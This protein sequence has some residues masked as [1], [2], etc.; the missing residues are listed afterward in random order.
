M[1][2]SEQL[3]I[4]G[5]LRRLLSEIDAFDHQRSLYNDRIVPRAQQALDISLS[6]YVVGK[7][8][9]VLLT[10]KYISNVVAARRER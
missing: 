6:E 8:S 3:T 1:H 7:T 10:D 9:F 2:Q 4:A 5:K